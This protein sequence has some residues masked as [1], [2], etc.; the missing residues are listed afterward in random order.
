[1]RFTGYNAHN[2]Y[3]LQWFQDRVLEVEPEFPQVVTLAPFVEYDSAAPN[4]YIVVRVGNLYMQYNRAIDYNADSGEFPDSLVVV[5]ERDNRQGTDLLVGLDLG[6]DYRENDGNERI[7]VHVC[8]RIYGGGA[9]GADILTV[10]VGYGSSLCNVRGPTPPAVPVA[11]T[12]TPPAPSPPALTIPRTWAPTTAPSRRAPTP[13]FGNRRPTSAPTIIVGDSLDD[14]G[15]AGIQQQPASTK[16]GGLGGILAASFSVLVCLMAIFVVYFK[17]YR[18]SKIPPESPSV[19]KEKETDDETEKASVHSGDSNSTVS[20]DESFET[21]SAMSPSTTTSSR[22]PRLPL[23]TMRRSLA[24]SIATSCALAGT[25]DDD[26]AELAISTYGLR[27]PRFHSDKELQEAT[28]ASMLASAKI[29][30]AAMLSSTKVEATT[31]PRRARKQSPSHSART[32]TNSSGTGENSSWLDWLGLNGTSPSCDYLNNICAYGT[33]RTSSS[34]S[35]KRKN[36]D[37]VI[38]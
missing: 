17:C 31:P 18:I 29:Q 30:A 20:S 6:E 32:G 38:L 10:S 1:M 8:N 37:G 27:M 36:E 21:E 13:T 24:H 9:F 12:Q 34:V 15:L 14:G 11:P 35:L 2:H 33:A 5:R 4:E 25:V 22:L 7:T 19:Y 16:G 3:M 26:D 28:P 23:E